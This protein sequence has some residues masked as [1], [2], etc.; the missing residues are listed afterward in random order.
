MLYLPV[1]KSGFGLKLGNWFF[2]TQ[3]QL[4]GQFL[5]RPKHSCPHGIFV[6]ISEHLLISAFSSVST[7]KLTPAFKVK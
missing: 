1:V 2:Y 6:M 4:L 3:G 5:L 7:A